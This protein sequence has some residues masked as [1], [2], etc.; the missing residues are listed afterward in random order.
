[1]MIKVSAF[2]LRID[3]GSGEVCE[4]YKVSKV[5]T[6][7]GLSGHQEIWKKIKKLA[8]NEAIKSFR[9]SSFIEQSK[10][11]YKIDIKFKKRI[12]NI[13]LDFDNGDS[14]DLV[15]FI[16]FKSDEFFNKSA[17]V[18]S[19]K[20][21][22]DNLV[23]RGYIN[24]EVDFIIKESEDQID[25]LGK[26]KVKGQKEISE[27]E[28]NKIEGVLDFETK[29]KINQ[30]KGKH[31]D[32]LK[33]SQRVEDIERV[34]IE[35][36]HYN[37]KLT[38]EEKEINKE[39]VKLVFNVKTGKRFNFSFEGN[40]T[41]GT[42]ELVNNI[43]REIVAGN[44]TLGFSEIEKSI[45]N[46]YDE[47]SIFKTK[48][49]IEKRSGFYRNKVPLENF[50]VKIEEG[51]KIRITKLFF[52]GNQRIRFSELE[53]LFYENA[54]VLVNRGFFNPKYIK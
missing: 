45:I 53:N 16:L 2:E 49:S 6:F 11:I 19:K 3:C 31:F 54:P 30:L 32:K 41:I 20:R 7:D 37:A 26:I 15:P 21:I 40:R 33:I 51:K 23:Q 50:Y 47:R 28:I 22:L 25:I 9:M 17:L 44:L 5:T 14:E 35:S 43:K 24:P 10:L 4:N 36:G 18:L 52:K 46:M 34:L 12:N 39:E 1:M 48:V 42:L 13:E 27:V 29:N 8:K 38:F